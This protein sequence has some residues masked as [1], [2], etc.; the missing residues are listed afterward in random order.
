MSDTESEL[1]EVYEGDGDE[2]TKSKSSLPS[3]TIA[4]SP[5]LSAWFLRMH[6]EYPALTATQFASMARLGFDGCN[7]G[8]THA[9]E[10]GAME[11]AVWTEIDSHVVS[12]V[13][14]RLGL[15]KTKIEVIAREI[16]SKK[17]EEEMNEFLE[18]QSVLDARKCTFID[19]FSVNL[20]HTPTSG[21]S[22][23]GER[24]KAVLPYTTGLKTTVILAMSW[25]DMVN[26][27]RPY[28]HFRLYPPVAVTGWW[29]YLVTFNRALRLA[30]DEI[31]DRRISW[32]D[33][34][35]RLRPQGL[36]TWA[37]SVG[38]GMDELEQ[39]AELRARH[40]VY[41]ATEGYSHSEWTPIYRRH[42]YAASLS[43]LENDEI[44]KLVRRVIVEHNDK[45]SDSFARDTHVLEFEADMKEHGPTEYELHEDE[46]DTPSQVFH[47][48]MQRLNEQVKK[49]AG[50]QRTV[51]GLLDL[52]RAAGVN[53]GMSRRD[54]VD[55][56]VFIARQHIVGS[57]RQWLGSL[58]GMQPVADDQLWSI[59]KVLGVRLTELAAQTRKMMRISDKVIGASELDVFRTVARGAGGLGAAVD[60]NVQRVAGR[61]MIVI[62][63]MFGI[64]AGEF[65]E[66]VPGLVG[67]TLLQMGVHPDVLALQPFNVLPGEQRRT[68]GT[69]EGRLLS[70]VVTKDEF[71]RYILFDL[72][73][74]FIEGRHLVMDG[75]SIHSRVT[76]GN[77]AYSRGYLSFGPL[78]DAQMDEGVDQQGGN[79]DLI[80][81]RYPN[82][83]P[84]DL[85]RLLESLPGRRFTPKNI[86][87]WATAA[88]VSRALASADERFECI[89]CR[90][91]ITLDARDP[92]RRR[93]SHRAVAD[94]RSRVYTRLRSDAILR[95][96]RAAMSLPGQLTLVYT[97][98]YQP[99]F[100]PIEKIVGYIKRTVRKSSFWRP[101]KSRLLLRRNL[102]RTLHRALHEIDPAN[103]RN[104]VLCSGFVP[105]PRAQSSKDTTMPAD[106]LN[107]EHTA[108]GSV[109]SWKYSHYWD[110]ATHS[111]RARRGWQLEEYKERLKH[112][113]AG[114]FGLRPP[115][116]YS[117]LENIRDKTWQTS[118]CLA[119]VD[120]R[121]N[122]RSPLWAGYP[123]FVKYTHM[124]QLAEEL[125]AGHSA[126]GFLEKV[127]ELSRDYINPHE[128]GAPVIPAGKSV[129][130]FTKGGARHLK[131]FKVRHSEGE[132]MRMYRALN[133]RELFI[134]TQEDGHTVLRNYWRLVCVNSVALGAQ[135]K[136]IGR[137]VKYVTA[138]DRT[139]EAAEEGRVDVPR[140]PD[141]PR[142]AQTDVALQA[143]QLISG[144][145]NVSTEA[146]RQGVLDG[147]LKWMYATRSVYA[148]LNPPKFHADLDADVHRDL[149]SAYT[150]HAGLRADAPLDELQDAFGAPGRNPLE[151]IPLANDNTLEPSK[152][153]LL[154][155]LR[156][157]WFSKTLVGA[158]TVRLLKHVKHPMSTSR[159]DSLLQSLGLA[160]GRARANELLL[161]VGDGAALEAHL[162]A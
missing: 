80:G 29:E 31:Q 92:H 142:L 93:D 119:T 84:N 121:D 53:S 96:S 50:V 40:K 4:G 25:P 41:V 148:L 153:T 127:G 11:H 138:R 48:E 23:I 32:H 75:A 47:Q 46:A 99:Q 105:R 106:T 162:N 30:M 56:V 88:E 157:R 55:R 156:K 95:Y 14:K 144:L 13:R 64:G 113:R 57:G 65:A 154:W 109:D 12:D 117:D 20:T 5:A 3:E 52:L 62:C 103:V 60:E 73:L 118:S 78:T 28:V 115:G 155:V 54:L 83:S 58:R 101:S 98:A 134:V 123:A 7:V 151:I 67:D 131:A 161:L 37:N 77:T 90:K 158:E 135:R 128:V 160:G 26:R 132:G 35:H 15:T 61:Y 107:V 104:T 129:Y 22:M 112:I 137:E 24:S 79:W 152:Y 68:D 102:T 87:E 126:M 143:S 42:D 159:F 63:L 8:T 141:R 108:A 76:S 69:G 34:R 38:D 149:I 70:L 10:R 36:R 140:E 27:D 145:A 146:Q 124:Q 136:L 66:A 71:N 130:R 114:V 89:K 97:P 44:M 120:K 43:R 116:H 21:W 49:S 74:S 39:V 33:I 81:G 82:R 16:V 91:A 139:E 59:M 86:D 150:R 133:A 94:S 51:R 100:N 9:S 17:G 122:V 110:R 85:Q 147:L 1:E 18:I 45:L 125:G 6:A 19:E 111:Y 72:P 2:V